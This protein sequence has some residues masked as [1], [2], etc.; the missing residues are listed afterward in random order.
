M[1]L[2][3]NKKV[4]K[5]MERHPNL[6]KYAEHFI[7]NPYDA[8]HS[9]YLCNLVIWFRHTLEKAGIWDVPTYFKFNKYMT[10]DFETWGHNS[11]W[12]HTFWSYL[13]NKLNPAL[14]KA[15][16]LADEFGDVDVEKEYF[17]YGGGWK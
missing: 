1:K 11:R 12:S 9:G 13:G 15:I 5:G 8:E 6:K 17:S 2:E 7:E 10:E 3:I 14:T 16:E 4:Q